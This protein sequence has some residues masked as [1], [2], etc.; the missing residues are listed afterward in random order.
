M[1]KASWIILIVSALV[2]IAILFAYNRKSKKNDIKTDTTDTVDNSGNNAEDPTEPI[3]QDDQI[4]SP[5][6]PN[7]SK[8][9]DSEINA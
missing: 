7:D 2:I 8:T 3:N 5:I 4:Y 6:L 9:P 1:S